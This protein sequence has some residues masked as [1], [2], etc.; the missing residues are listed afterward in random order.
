[1]HLDSAGERFGVV[2]ATRRA[3]SF[4]LRESRYPAR[5]G[6][7]DHHHSEPYFSFVVRGE[8]HERDPRREI[9]YRRGSLHF[10]PSQDPHRGETGPEGATVLSLT[11]SGRVA[12]RLD[13]LPAAR[14][15]ESPT[16]AALAARGAHEFRA[17]D[18]A[19]DLALEALCLEIAA[20]HLRGA[21]QA[22]HPA[23]PAWLEQV[24]ELLHAA[25]DR[26]VSLGDLSAEAGVHP[27]NL[28]RVFRRHHGC[29]PGAYL[30]RLRIEAARRA[31]IET[32]D[33]I[34]DIAL[35]AGFSSQAH[36]TRV[37]HRMMGGSPARYRRSER[38]ATRRSDRSRT[39]AV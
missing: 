10:H 29:T 16:A 31:L 32:L 3:G 23:P 4:L 22:H 36:F 12:L 25:R 30:R 39:L 8:I 35:A 33:P 19:S 24:C 6:L 14:A 34:A 26:Q 15:P 37:F 11:A 38:T 21:C 13:R 2:L 20:A 9:L 17:T 1:M 27:A 28:A 5:L 18:S 7:P